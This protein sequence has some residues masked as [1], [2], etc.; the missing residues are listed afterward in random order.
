MDTWEKKVKYAVE[1]EHQVVHYQVTPRYD[2]DRVVP[3]GFEMK[4]T[5]YKPGGA[6]GISFDEYVPNEMFS[7]YDQQWHNMGQYAP[8]EFRY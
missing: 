7:L 4:A 1:K 6:P 5:G 3:I 2:G 8:T